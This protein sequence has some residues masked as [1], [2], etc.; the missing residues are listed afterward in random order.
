MPFLIVFKSNSSLKTNSIRMR[1]L[2]PSHEEVNLNYY[3]NQIKN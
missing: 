3:A 1:Y 2:S